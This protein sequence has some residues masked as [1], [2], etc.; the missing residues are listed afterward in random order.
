MKPI[1]R[2][3]RPDYR[4]INIVYLFIYLFLDLFLDLFIYLFVCLSVYLIILPGQPTNKNYSL[5]WQHF[6]QPEKTSVLKIFK[7]RKIPETIQNFNF[8]KDEREGKEDN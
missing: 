8:Y 5:Y 4:K 3:T 2:L 1:E 6:K 7:P